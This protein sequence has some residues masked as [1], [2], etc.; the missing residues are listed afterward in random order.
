MILD[1]FSI[2]ELS[3][4]TNKSRPTIYKYIF[5]YEKGDLNDIPYNFVRLFDFINKTNGNRKEII[6]FCEDNFSKIDT[7]ERVNTIVKL[8][9]E[10]KNILDLEKITSYI[11]EEIKKCQK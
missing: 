4:L 1:Y 2:T 9:K 7:D 11:L 5:S 8:I 10:N 3:I 6:K